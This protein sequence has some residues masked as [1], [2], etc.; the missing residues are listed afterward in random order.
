[1][2]KLI[3]NNLKSDWLNPDPSGPTRKRHNAT[4]LHVTDRHRADRMSRVPS[5]PSILRLWRQICHHAEVDS[6]TICANK[7]CDRD[8]WISNGN[9]LLC[10]RCGAEAV[11]SDLDHKQKW[12]LSVPSSSSM[13]GLKRQICHHAEVDSKNQCSESKTWAKHQ[14][15]YTWLNKNEQQ[16]PLLRHCCACHDLTL[17]TLQ[18]DEPHM[19]WPLCSPKKS[20]G[21]THNGRFHQLKTE[22]QANEETDKN[23]TQKVI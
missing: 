6:K 19:I 12:L 3:N 9:V 5:S 17:I 4:T 13:L 7:R 18:R 16:N 21:W 11:D 10:W 15:W 20:V 14:S 1:M 23:M 2:K 22:L 8:A